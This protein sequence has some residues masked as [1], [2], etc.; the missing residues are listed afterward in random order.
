M[1]GHVLKEG[2]K[3]KRGGDGTRQLKTAH[4]WQPNLNTK[5]L[6]GAKKKKKSPEIFKDFSSFLV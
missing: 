3:V 5:T 4:S 1:L 2:E 6:Q